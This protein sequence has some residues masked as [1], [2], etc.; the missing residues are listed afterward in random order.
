MFLFALSVITAGLG[1][2]Y[3]DSCTVP[4][5]CL[6]HSGLLLYVRC[7]HPLCD[8]NHTAVDLRQCMD[9]LGPQNG[10]D[11][12]SD[13]GCE[14]LGGGCT[15]R[16]VKGTGEKP[17]CVPIARNGN[18]TYAPAVRVG[19]TQCRV[20]CDQDYGIL[21]AA[22]EM[23]CACPSHA[24][25]PCDLNYT[26]KDEHRMP[27]CFCRSSKPCNSTDCPCIT[28]R[29]MIAQTLDSLTG[30]L[31]L[32]ALYPFD[33]LFRVTPC[34]GFKE[35]DSNQCPANWTSHEVDEKSL[36][37]MAWGYQFYLQGARAFYQP[38]GLNVSDLRANV[39]I[40]I[41]HCLGSF[42]KVLC[43]MPSWDTR[44]VKCIPEFRLPTSSDLR[45]EALEVQWEDRAIGKISTFNETHWT[46][47]MESSKKCEI[48]T[49]IALASSPTCTC[50]SPCIEPSCGCYPSG[51]RLFKR[52]DPKAM[53]FGLCSLSGNDANI[54]WNVSA[55]HAEKELCP[56]RAVVKHLEAYERK[57]YALGYRFYTA[58]KWLRAIPVTR[59][60]RQGECVC[61]DQCEYG[62]PRL[63]CRLVPDPNLTL[64]ICH[65]PTEF[66]RGIGLGVVSMNKVPC[67]RCDGEKSKLSPCNYK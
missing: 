10:L 28:K 48:K 54:L 37:A 17:W 8:V 56:D 49:R 36:L 13:K 1:I 9:N 11:T 52:Y 27:S 30:R 32:R 41:E 4:Y 58:K 23:K 47:S 25:V 65:T 44:L 21:N 59:P 33:D 38:T 31:D 45:H 14:F 19:T 18:G 43:L 34:R 39:C 62:R 7:G 51:Y 3:R 60:L 57:L 16:F 15:R 53:K 55:C 67:L 35:G 20:E 66:P 22:G 12:W 50:L 24:L 46:C 61:L 5:G 40:C 64:S 29:G 6:G 42:P 63:Q 26:E 2:Y